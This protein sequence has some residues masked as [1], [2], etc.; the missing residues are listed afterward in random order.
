MLVNHV[1]IFSTRCNISTGFVITEI[2]EKNKK[3]LCHRQTNT[4][5]NIGD[6][7]APAIGDRLAP[8][9]KKERAVFGKSTMSLNL[10]YRRYY[11]GNH[12]L[13]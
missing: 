11:N 1:I 13:A 8:Y 4:M 3:Q 5:H 10:N 12:V 6:R 7:L 2:L 9:A